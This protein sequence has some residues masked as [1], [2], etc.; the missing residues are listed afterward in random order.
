MSTREELYENI[1]HVLIGHSIEIS[2]VKDEIQIVLGN[3]EVQ[4]RT[5]EV[6]VL[7]EDR[8][9]FLVNKFLIAKT[10]KGCTPRTIE[11]YKS[12]LKFILDKLGKT[13]DDITADDIRLYIALRTKRDGISK[14]SADNEL[15]ILRTF[16]AYLQS[17]ELVLKNPMLKVEKIKARRMQK[18][19]LTE[20]EVEKIRYAAA[21]GERETAV[22]EILLSTGIRISELIGIQIKE[23]EGDRVLVHG[24]GEKDRYAYLNARAQMAIMRYM[25]CRKDSNPYL[26]PGGIFSDDKRGK[27][28]P[29]GRKWI[30][31]WKYPENIENGTHISDSSIERMLR[32]LAQ[33]AGVERANPHKFRRT[34]ATM[35]LRRGMPVEQVSKM[36]GHEN[37]QTT[38]IYLDLTEEELAQ[39]HKKYVI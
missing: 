12:Y 18:E 39:A 14:V 34:C 9:R 21:V 20:I 35:A 8:N 31:W 37:I 25:K 27:H 23:I 16:F 28:T 38:Q 1:L 24:K 4:E 5:T 36:L 26:F 10:V 33:K 19:A 3:Y 22:V 11:T 13:V 6:A 30:G 17:E 2:E 32:K 7:H 15:R 29:L